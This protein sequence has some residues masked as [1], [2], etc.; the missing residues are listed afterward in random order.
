MQPVAYK[1]IRYSTA[2]LVGLA[3]DVVVVKNDVD[4]FVV[5]GVTVVRCPVEVEGVLDSEVFVELD[6]VV[7]SSGRH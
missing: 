1:D 7:A 6:L 2:E 4:L 3:I 5:E